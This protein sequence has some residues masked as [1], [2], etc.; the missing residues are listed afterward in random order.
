[1]AGPRGADVPGNRAD[2]LVWDSVAGNCRLD[3]NRLI[4]RPLGFP[5]RAGLKSR[6]PNNRS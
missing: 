6:R 4:G 3:S 5:N 1:M 2:I